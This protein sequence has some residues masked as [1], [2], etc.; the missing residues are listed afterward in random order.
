[1]RKVVLLLVVLLIIPVL[2]ALSSFN[3]VANTSAWIGYWGSII[4]GVL[5]GCF[6]LIG[7]IFAFILEKEKSYIE[8]LPDKI[9]NIQAIKEIVLKHKFKIISLQSLDSQREFEQVVED[10]KEKVDMLFRDI[11]VFNSDKESLFFKA[12]KVD[13][14]VFNAIQ[15]YC[16]SL[17]IIKKNIKRLKT[18]DIDSVNKLYREI[19]DAKEFQ[20][21]ILNT[22]KEIL[23]QKEE[24]YLNYLYNAGKSKAIIDKFNQHSYLKNIKK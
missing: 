23:E 19:T 15:S 2:V 13:T 20:K 22:L 18:S 17:E 16:Y 9:V 11:D 5:G 3:L 10:V 1:M 8:Q 6:T 7:V 24:Y 14:D 21:D 12:S 4:G